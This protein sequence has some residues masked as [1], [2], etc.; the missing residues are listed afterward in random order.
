MHDETGVHCELAAVSGRDQVRISVTA[1]ALLRLKQGDVGGPGQ[2]ISRGQASY[3]AADHGDPAERRPG[4][5]RG[6]PAAP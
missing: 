4:A 1:E 3:S 5:G 6:R 2:D